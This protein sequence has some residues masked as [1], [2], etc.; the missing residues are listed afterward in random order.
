MG[1]PA[2]EMSEPA[3]APEAPVS[4][5]T[6]EE[7]GDGSAVVKLAQPVLFQREQLTRL[8]I[9]RIT[10]RHM[11]AARWRVSGASTMGDAVSFAASLIEPVGVV[12]ELDGALAAQ[13]AVEVALILFAKSSQRRSAAA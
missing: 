2:M 4:T 5:Y 3:A 9:P 12:D 10:G 8:T 13:L 11:R 6:I 7:N 1:D